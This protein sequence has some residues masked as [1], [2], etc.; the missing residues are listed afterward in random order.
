[1]S[2]LLTRRHVSA[3]GTVSEADYSPC[4]AYRYR[5]ERRWGDAPVQTWIMLNP[6]TATELADDPT[7]ARVSRRARAAGAG[8]VRILNLFAFRA[9]LP[10]DFFAAADPVGP[11]T[12]RIFDALNGQAVAGWGVHGARFGRG[13]AVAARLRDRGIALSHLGLTRDGHPRH[14]LYVSY[15]VAPRPWQE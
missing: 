7:I 5:L 8:G 1:M 2:D 15:A 6:S 14:P 13:P 3:D 4:L 9:T 12:D 10:R 11:K